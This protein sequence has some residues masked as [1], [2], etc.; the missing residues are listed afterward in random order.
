[1]IPRLVCEVKNDIQQLKDHIRDAMATGIRNMF[2]NSW[3]ELEHHR[4][5]NG[6]RIEIY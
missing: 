3:T 1:M 6:A 4:T 2:Q 5:I